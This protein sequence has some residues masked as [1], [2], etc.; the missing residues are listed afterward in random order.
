MADSAVRFD[1]WL[2]EMRTVFEIVLMRGGAERFIKPHRR[3]GVSVTISAT[4]QFLLRR[5]NVA[6]VTFLMAR[7]ARHDHPVIK[8][9][10]IAALQRR[11]S[12]RHFVRIEMRLMR[13]LFESELTQCF[14]KIRDRQA[15]LHVQD[16]P[17]AVANNAERAFRRRLKEVFAGVAFRAGIVIRPRGNRIRR[18]AAISDVTLV[19]EQPLVLLPFVIELRFFMKQGRDDSDWNDCR[20]GFILPGRSRR[21]ITRDEAQKGNLGHPRNNQF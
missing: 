7:E 11:S 1:T 12:S 10:A 18:I 3:S 2:I 6:T 13:K 9:M 21:P 19:A 4:A 17:F 5:M 14:R 16:F 8:T 15:L 20:R